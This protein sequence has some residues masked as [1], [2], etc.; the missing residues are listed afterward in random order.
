MFSLSSALITGYPAGAC[1]TLRCIVA[2]FACGET[3]APWFG[4]TIGAASC[5]RCCD[6][7]SG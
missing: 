3:G 5:V 6:G 1:T 2:L 4:S 7:S